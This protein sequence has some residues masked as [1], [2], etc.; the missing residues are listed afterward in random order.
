MAVTI[1]LKKTD[2][3]D[4]QSC[5]RKGEEKIASV[6]LESS[7]A[8]TTQKS[9]T[10]VT[11]SS[12]FSSMSKSSIYISSS[13]SLSTPPFAGAVCANQSLIGRLKAECLLSSLAVRIPRFDLGAYPSVQEGPTKAPCTESP[14]TCHRE[15]AT[16]PPFMETGNIILNSPINNRS[17]HNAEAVIQHLSASFK[18][19]PVS[20]PASAAHG[21][22]R[23]PAVPKEC[24][25]AGSGTGRKVCVSGLNV[26]RWSKRGTGEL[27]GKRKKNERQTKAMSGDYSSCGS[28]L[29]AGAD[30][31]TGV[32]Y[33][34]QEYIQNLYK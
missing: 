3:S 2:V 13:S 30:T 8:A 7:V 5:S 17:P 12:S 10:Y 28:M 1:K 29:S 32:S 21:K 6:C 22:T 9:K 14:Y 33:H 15:S 24:S 34:C 25:G 19:P 18:L 20:P 31:Y 23:P 4:H 26:S 11:V 16:S 27:N